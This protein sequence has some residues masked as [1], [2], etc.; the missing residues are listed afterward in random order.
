MVLKAGRAI[1]RLDR[2]TA[3]AGRIWRPSTLAAVLRWAERQP[4]SLY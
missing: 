1:L 3:Q 2:P 4:V